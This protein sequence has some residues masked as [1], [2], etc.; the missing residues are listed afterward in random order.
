MS[1]VFGFDGLGTCS[2]VGTYDADGG[3]MEVKHQIFKSWTKSWETLCAEA[4]AFATEK[5]RDRVINLSVSEDQNEGVVIV[6][7]WE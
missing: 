7:Y 5:G 3:Y 4:A 2:R 1:I 6:W